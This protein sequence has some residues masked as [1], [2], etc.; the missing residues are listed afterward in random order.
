MAAEL[1]AYAQVSVSVSTV[2]SR[3][4]FLSGRLMYENVYAYGRLC[5]TFV[6][7]LFMT[8]VF[9]M[10]ICMTNVYTR[11]ISSAR[12]LPTIDMCV[13]DTE[14]SVREILH[15]EHSERLKS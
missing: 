12:T 4:R 7:E 11:S 3:Q 5:N 1:Y 15:H 9:T 14:T 6:R 2:L 10:S 13:I 8:N